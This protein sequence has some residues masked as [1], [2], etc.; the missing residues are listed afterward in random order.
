MKRIV[1]FSISAVLILAIGW[2]A[3]AS[4]HNGAPV[5]AAEVRRGAI[6][7]FIEERGQTRLPM[8]YLITMPYSGRIQAIALREGD[9]VS[10]GQV[11]AQM[12]PKD[13]EISLDAAQAA[14]DQL[15]AQIAE[16]EDT[17]VEQTTKLQ[18]ERFV[19]SMAHTVAAAE[20]RVEAGRAKLNYAEKNLGRIQSLHERGA[21]TEDELDVANV[22]YVESS[23]D[24]HQDELVNSAMAS[25][26]S[27]TVL[28]PTAID[29]YIDR[30]SLSVAVLRKELMEA[31]ANL[32]K[33]RN[34]VERGTMRSPVN[35][36]VLERNIENE[37]QVAAGTVLLSIGDLSELEAEADVLSQDVVRVREGNLVE[38]YGA[39]IGKEPVLGKVKRVYPAGFTKISS[40][41]VEQQR[42]KVIISFDSG[43]LP[44]LVTERG[45]GVGYRVRVRI[46]MARNEDALVIPR[47]ALFRG[48]EGN[49]EVFAVRNKTVEL[50][51]VRVGLMN[52]S[53]VEITSGL[54]EKDIVVLAPEIS[55]TA[56]TH[57]EPVLRQRAEM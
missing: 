52:D 16:T 23:I 11:V 27:A 20:A 37:R 49:W 38:I 51:N 34:D 12:V 40:L 42:V 18:S 22:E 9:P 45:L 48:A 32:Q 5:E 55:L 35:G 39:A 44:S 28:L 4:L 41:G 10:E 25:L 1:I 36:I 13:L 57:V 15:D 56:G 33:V 46:F 24:F 43:E 50:Q 26:Q 29:Q 6:S 30:K 19:E 17:S 31:E 47:A 54:S 8:T 53:V 3:Y 7:E 14:A 21:T 2:G